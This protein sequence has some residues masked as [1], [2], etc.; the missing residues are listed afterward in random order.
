[1]PY[2]PINWKPEDQ[3]TASKLNAMEAGISAAAA[4]A[5]EIPVMVVQ[6]VNNYLT[7][8]Y[9]EIKDAITAGKLVLYFS[10]YTSGSTT[11]YGMG[12]ISILS[13]DAGSYQVNVTWPYDY[14]NINSVPYWRASNP[15]DYPLYSDF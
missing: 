11:Q 10:E 8:T 15:N 2:T 3:I 12:Y 9:Q 4:V 7:A 1:M 14:P 5:E 13:E 6:S